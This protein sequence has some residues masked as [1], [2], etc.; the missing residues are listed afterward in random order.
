MREMGSNE[1]NRRHPELAD[2]FEAAQDKD[3]AVPSGSAGRNT[4]PDLPRYQGAISPALQNVVES[5]SLSPTL[6]IDGRFN[7]ISMKIAMP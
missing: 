5:L 4:P 6:I 7:I 2:F 3:F 1:I